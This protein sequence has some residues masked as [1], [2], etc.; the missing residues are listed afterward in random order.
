MEFTFFCIVLTN[1]IMLFKNIKPNP[2]PLCKKGSVYG[3]IETRRSKYGKKANKRKIGRYIRTYGFDLTETWNLDTVIHDWLSDHIGGFFRECG[4]IDSWSDYTLDG[5]PWDTVSNH[6]L[7]IQAED[8]RKDAY[9]NKVSEFLKSNT[10]EVEKF[11]AFIIPRLR[12]FGRHVW[13]YPATDEFS[14]LESWQ[15]CISKIADEL[16][17]I[18]YSESFI[19]NYFGL[20]D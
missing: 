2:Y 6:V 9:L 1:K 14:T 4:S 7:C 11:K 10:N 20:W 17:N 15:E 8:A 5:E 3:C 19:E 13:G 16:E 12:Y 18:G